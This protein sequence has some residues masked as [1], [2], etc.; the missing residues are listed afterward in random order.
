MCCVC[1]RA[2]LN[3]SAMKTFR[4]ELKAKKTQNK[5]NLK[6]GLLRLCSDCFKPIYQGCRH[7]C[8]PLAGL[9]NVSAMIGAEGMEKLCHS[10]ISER[11]GA[12]GDHIIS[13]KGKLGGKPMKVAINKNIKPEQ[14]KQVFGL[15]EAVA[16]RTEGN[17]TSKCVLR[18]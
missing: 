3:G 10:Y 6:P 2:R 16:L 9:N 17:F 8:S 12:S 11:S 15:K 14:A 4:K 18:I 1:T 13:L 7:D 5:E